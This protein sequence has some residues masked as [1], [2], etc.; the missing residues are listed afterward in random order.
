VRTG[1]MRTLNIALTSADIASF[2]A[3]NNVTA[4]Q[5]PTCG[6]ELRPTPTAPES[7]NPAPEDDSSTDIAP[8]TMPEPAPED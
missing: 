4:D 3:V 2:L 1:P 5:L 7:P 8:D 6:P